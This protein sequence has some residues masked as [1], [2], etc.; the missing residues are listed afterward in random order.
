MALAITDVA[1]TSAN[2][3]IDTQTIND[4]AEFTGSE[5]DRGADT[6]VER[7]TGLLTITGFASAPSA[8]GY[9][10]VRIAP[11]SGS[12]GTLF[13]DGIGAAVAP[14]VAD[15]LY[16]IPVQLTMPA[17]ARYVQF[18]VGNESG[19]NTDADGTSLAAFWQAVTV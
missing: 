5:L 9:M 18:I 7:A 11:L 17:G 10:T 2:T 16:N 1:K 8:G 14:V 4:G 13:D 3:G 15:A 12:S 6:A 19:Q